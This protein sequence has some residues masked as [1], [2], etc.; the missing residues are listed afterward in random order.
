MEQHLRLENHWL[1]CMAAAGGGARVTRIVGGMTVANPHIAGLAFNF[2][3]LRG[4]QPARLPAVL[5]IGGT[6]LAACGRPPAVFLSPAS[7]DMVQLGAALT[8]LGWRRLVQQSVLVR[9]LS[10]ADRLE[11]SGGAIS[12]ESVTPDLVP[13]WSRTLVEAYGVDPITAEALTEAWE[14]VLRSPGEGARSLGCLA[15]LDGRP[16]GTG[17]LWMQ[18][19]TAGLYCGA[20]MPEHRRQGIHR[21]TVHYRLSAAA[22][23][24]CTAATLQT[25]AGSPVERLCTGELGFSVAYRREL[26]AP[27]HPGNLAAL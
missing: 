7:G 23:A 12:V 6:L 14:S 16:A 18:S 2:I 15:R 25:E 9:P 20:V 13:L 11:V 22:A 26:W 21:A 17:L 3:A 5:E 10:P 1:A 8:D 4:G 24:G 27:S 19:G